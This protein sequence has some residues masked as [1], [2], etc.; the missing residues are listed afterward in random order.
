MN[1]ENALKLIDATI[2]SYLQ[3]LKILNEESKDPYLVAKKYLLL[4]MKRYVK[5]N[6]K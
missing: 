5:E 6:L 2:D 4:D 3:I 1:R